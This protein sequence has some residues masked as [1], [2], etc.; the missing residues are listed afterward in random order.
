MSTKIK[1]DV[2][3]DVVC[4]WCI[5]GYNSLNQAIVELGMEDQIELEWQPFEL[6]PDMPAEGENLR[7]H[8]ARKYGSSAQD[9]AKARENITQRGADQGFAFN[10]NDDSKIVNTFDAHILLDYA[11]SQG[12]QTALK[13]RLFSAYFTEHKDVSDRNV[14]ASEV[15][16][17]G[18]DADEAMALQDKPEV[19]AHLKAEKDQWTAAGI[20][21]VPTVV[22]NR[23]SALNGAHPVETYKQVLTE[24]LAK[25]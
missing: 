19:R 9:S 16:A 8:V 14:L 7:D 1:L 6:N 20:S 23:T 5:I 24:L 11:K 21:S 3:S 22:F 13:L 2:V 15:A 25:Q 10:F 12:K 4:P 17:V 18:L